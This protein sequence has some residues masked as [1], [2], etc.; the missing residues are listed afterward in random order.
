VNSAEDESHQAIAHFFLEGETVPHFG[1][2]RRGTYARGID[3]VTAVLMADTIENDYVV[4][5][6]LGASTDWVVTMPTRRFYVDAAYPATN[7]PAADGYLSCCAA[8]VYDRS[9][10][11]EPA[12]ARDLQLENDVNVISFLPPLPRSRACSVPVSWS[13]SCRQALRARCA[14]RC[15]RSPLPG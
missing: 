7:D 13:T 4:D 6:A 2:P 3:A 15:P 5:P 12:T 11:P 10:Q 9:G 1:T 14:F 8:F